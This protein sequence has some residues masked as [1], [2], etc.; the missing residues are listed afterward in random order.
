MDGSWERWGGV[1]G[2]DECA[3]EGVFLSGGAGGGDDSVD[4]S[5]GSSMV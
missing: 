5:I 2:C 3:G 1:K 4:A